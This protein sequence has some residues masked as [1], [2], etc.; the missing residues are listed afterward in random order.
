MM[1]NNQQLI[2]AVQQAMATQQAMSNVGQ[3][4]GS[5]LAYHPSTQYEPWDYTRTVQFTLNLTGFGL[6]IVRG[7]VHYS[8]NG[9]GAFNAGP[10]NYWIS[11]VN[12]WSAPTP[13]WVVNANANAPGQGERQ[14]AVNA[15]NINHQT[16]YPV[17]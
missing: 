11:G 17:V 14:A 5:I 6:T 7:H 12:N 10:G 8:S 13:G 1:P 9:Q 16:N 4:T 3:V 15:F 2:A